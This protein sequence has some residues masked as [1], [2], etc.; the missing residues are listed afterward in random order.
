MALGSTQPLTEMCTRNLPGGKVWPE[1]KA[2]KHHHI[3]APIVQKM[4]DPRSL[5]TLLASTAC[6]RNSFAFYGEICEILAN[7]GR[8]IGLAM[9]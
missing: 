9:P 1:R 7:D 4:W 2:D 5:T 3:C 8:K 6:Y